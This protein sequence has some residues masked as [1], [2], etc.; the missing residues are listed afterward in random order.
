MPVA[1]DYTKLNA[2]QKRNID[3]IQTLP[4]DVQDMV[5]DLITKPGT[6]YTVQPKLYWSTVRFEGAYTAGPPTNYLIQPGTMVQAFGYKV[7]D[8]VKSAG[9]NTTVPTG[10]VATRRLTNL[11]VGGTQTEDNADV[12]V[13]GLGISLLSAG[14]DANSKTQMQQ[15]ELAKAVVSNTDTVLSL[16]TS[17]KFYLGRMDYYPQPGGLDGEATSSI[18]QGFTAN[19]Q[20]QYEKIMRNGIAAQGNLRKLP[21]PIRWQ[22]IGSNKKDTSLTVQFTVTD[23]ISLDGLAGTASAVDGNAYPGFAPQASTIFQDFGVWLQTIEVS[24]RSENQ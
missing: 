20:G 3:L 15:P 1:I 14:N 10:Y 7:G 18:R 19:A 6:D 13:W 17:T 22:S 5:L 21:S 23:Q 11:T 12:I 16:S 9:F 8:P 4:P 24:D 2:K